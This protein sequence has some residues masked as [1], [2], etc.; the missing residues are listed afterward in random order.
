MASVTGNVAKEYWDDFG[1]VG[2]RSELLKHR[3]YAQNPSVFAV[4]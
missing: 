3:R 4:E 2:P 1:I